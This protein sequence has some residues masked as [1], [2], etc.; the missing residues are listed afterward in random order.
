MQ[1]EEVVKRT[2]LLMATLL[3]GP[4]AA[5]AIQASPLTFF[6]KF[7]GI[8]SEDVTTEKAGPKGGYGP[9]GYGAP[10]DTSTT[11]TAVEGSGSGQGSGNG[12]YD[13]Y[14]GYGYGPYGGGPN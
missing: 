10:Y 12:P 7:F 13:G 11:S 4:M 2:A 8:S 6:Q 5:S 1:K 14:P 9:Y 3:A